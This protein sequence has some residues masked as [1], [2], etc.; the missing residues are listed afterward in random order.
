MEHD[1]FDPGS[2]SQPAFDH[3]CVSTGVCTLLLGKYQ[4]L[5][6]H[7]INGRVEGDKNEEVVMPANLH[8]LGNASD[9]PA[10]RK[11]IDS[12]DRQKGSVDKQPSTSRASSPDMARNF[13]AGR[14]TSVASR[15]GESFNGVIDRD[16]RDFSCDG[17]HNLRTHSDK[18]H[19]QSGFLSSMSIDISADVGSRDPPAEGAVKNLALQYTRSCSFESCNKVLSLSGSNVS[20][21]NVHPAPASWTVNLRFSFVWVLIVFTTTLI[22]SVVSA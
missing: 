15:T 7:S 11:A 3:N 22:I 18:V 6:S 10:K 17:L 19:L 12:T 20:F 5:I 2:D 1:L 13:S 9:V 8:G 21:D 4:L 16:A 14:W